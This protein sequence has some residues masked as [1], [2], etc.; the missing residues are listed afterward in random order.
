MKGNNGSN[1]DAIRVCA[2]VPYPPATSPSQRY[3]I[4]QWMPLLKA[5]G[6]SVDLIPFADE[7]LMRHLHK[8]GRH[9]L[10]AVA[11]VARFLRRFADVAATARYDVVLIHRAASIGGPALLERAV[12]LLGKP[13]IYDFDDAIFLLNT[14]QAN[15]RFGWLKFPRKTATICRISSHVVTGNSYLADYARQYNRRVTVIPSSVNTDCYRPVG[16]NGSNT[17]VVVGW[18][19]SSTSQT[20]LE[21]FAPTLAE[22]LARR[23]VE[24][25]IVSDREPVLPGISFEWR[26]WSAAT[27]VEELSKFDIGIMPMPDDAWARGKCSMKALLYMSV[28]VATVCS[29]VGT[30]CEVIR[31]GE[32]GFLA[33]TAA[34]WIDH[35][36][37][38]IDDPALRN[39]LGAAGRE[40][41]EQR[42]SMRRC[43]ELFARVVRETSVDFLVESGYQLDA[44]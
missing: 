41:I 26:P 38:L 10:K 17:R 28:G 3:R 35:L 33:S 11:G 16:K 24:L 30:N 27:E 31:H 6:I 25:R 23:R 37:A 44:Q 2:L 14:T 1:T 15:R 36:E 29:A 13:V 12:K 20:H 9:A 32:N 39:G 22:L 43:A 42:Y 18:M 34:D 5:Q 8:P 21:M 40:T 7:A 19:G 4:E